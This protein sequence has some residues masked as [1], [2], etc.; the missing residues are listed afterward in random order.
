M[1]MID[2]TWIHD[3][4]L[5]DHELCSKV[6]KEALLVLILILACNQK[7][8]FLVEQ[9]ML[10][11]RKNFLNEANKICY[12]VNK[13]CLLMIIAFKKDIII[14]WWVSCCISRP[15]VAFLRLS[16][17]LYDLWWPLYGVL[18]AFMAKY[19]FGLVFVYCGL[20]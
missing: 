10:L 16:M 13:K 11:L 3:N 18:W 6:L 15:F 12:K 14:T 1:L 7:Q 4:A 5:F 20:T 9:I 2:W 17:V 8:N 19:W